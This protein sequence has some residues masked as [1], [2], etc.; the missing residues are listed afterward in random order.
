[1]KGRHTDLDNAMAEMRKLETMIYDHN[2]SNSKLFKQAQIA[3]QRIN[4]ANK[5]M[6]WVWDKLDEVLTAKANGKLD[7]YLESNQDILERVN[8]K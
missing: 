3:V 5:D 4:M 1:M 6:K 2:V 8:Q 7:A